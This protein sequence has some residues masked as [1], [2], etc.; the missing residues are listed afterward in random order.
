M[1]DHIVSTL[2]QSGSQQ[3]QDT[4]G[5]SHNSNNTEMYEML[6]MATHE[7]SSEYQQLQICTGNQ[8]LNKL[9]MEEYCN[10]TKSMKRILIIFVLIYTA[11]LVIITAIAITPQL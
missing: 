5:L 10:T 7:R 4:S 2:Y 8:G 9:K 3:P 11:M 1:V 6:T